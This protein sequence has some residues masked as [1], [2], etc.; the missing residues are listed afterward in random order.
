[1]WPQA[2]HWEKKE[3]TQTWL[4]GASQRTVV[5]NG[6]H[7]DVQRE[8]KH[9]SDSILLKGGKQR[10]RL[11]PSN[12]HSDNR[13]KEDAARSF[14][15][16]VQGV[17]MRRWR[18][19]R[20]GG[21][22]PWCREYEGHFIMKPMRWAPFVLKPYLL[23]LQM[24][25][26]GHSQ[27]SEEALEPCWP[28]EPSPAPAAASNNTAHRS[29]CRPLLVHSFPARTPPSFRPASQFPGGFRG[30]EGDVGDKGWEWQKGGWERVPTRK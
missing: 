21:G 6:C 5:T 28:G 19:Q 4:T 18:H 11:H 26:K 22:I 23:I 24:W 8:C 1:M 13:K 15:G 10:P 25:S 29:Q 12:E 20:P 17:R 3:V 7:Y 27:C 2:N 30:W 14:P 16:F 9:Q